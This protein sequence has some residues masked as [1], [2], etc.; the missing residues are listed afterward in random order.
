M[1]AGN[2]RVQPVIIGTNVVAC[3]IDTS[4]I[5]KISVVHAPGLIAD[6]AS[7]NR[8]YQ[9]RHEWPMYV[10]LNGER[11]Y[12]EKLM[13]TG[14]LPLNDLMIDTF[15]EAAGQNQAILAARFNIPMNL[16]ISFSC[17]DAANNLVSFKWADDRFNVPVGIAGDT[18]GN[19]LFGTD[20]LKET[21]PFN[22]TTS[23][24]AIAGKFSEEIFFVT[25]YDPRHIINLYNNTPAKHVDRSP[26]RFEEFVALANAA[27]NITLTGL[28]RKFFEGERTAYV[29]EARRL[30]GT[31]GW[32]LYDRV[33]IA[34]GG[35]DDPFCFEAYKFFKTTPPQI[36]EAVLEMTAIKNPFIFGLTE[37][38]SFGFGSFYKEEMAEIG[39]PA[40]YAR[41]PQ[42]LFAL[43]MLADP[44]EHT[45]IVQ[46]KN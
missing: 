2:L 33:V 40:S 18:A 10:S 16:G 32:S 3:R 46:A 23:V 1:N 42:G 41:G 45:K 35:K 39:K 25:T 28:A 37:G 4:K 9:V 21:N 7:G 22:I 6:C 14:Y 43:Y 13:R 11:I 44:S 24:L 19:R 8:T 26:K 17:H 30:L 12:D 15:K 20:D 31:Y 29:A 38:G 27:E 5:K 36:I 34:L